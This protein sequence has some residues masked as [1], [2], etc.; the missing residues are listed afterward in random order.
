M[1]VRDSILPCQS[2]RSQKPT[3]LLLPF[4][5]GQAGRDRAPECAVPRG[6]PHRAAQ[7]LRLHGVGGARGAVFSP[8]HAH[9]AAAG[10]GGGGGGCAFRTEESDPSHSPAAHAGTEM[11]RLCLVA[12]CP[13]QVWSAL[14]KADYL[15]AFAAHPRIG[16][17]AALRKV[18][19]LSS[20]CV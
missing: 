18:G 16:D 13:T 2:R 4:K 11:Y 5:P 20:S 10:D 3:P 15:E 19:F 6:A 1:S 14:R 12:C 17:A 8:Y 7:D 9:R